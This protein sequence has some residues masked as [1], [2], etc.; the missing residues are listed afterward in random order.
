MALYDLEVVYRKETHNSDAD[1]LSRV[2]RMGMIRQLT[3][4]YV[5]A[6]SVVDICT[7]LGKDQ[8]K[9]PELF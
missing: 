9:N 1:T 7:L 5:I 6:L 8:Q 3:S 2:T 4:Q